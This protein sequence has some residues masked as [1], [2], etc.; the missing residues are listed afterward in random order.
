[1]PRCAAWKATPWAWLPALAAM[2]P[3]LRFGFAQ[4]EELVEG[5]ALFEGAGALQV[6]ELQMQRQSGEFGKMMR[7]LAWRDVDG[8]LDARACGLNADKGYGFQDNLLTKNDGNGKP[9]AALAGG[10]LGVAELLIRFVRLFPR[11]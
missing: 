3:R 5:A 9:P 1:M 4:R 8:A 2:T 7:E 10:G 6:F 11:A